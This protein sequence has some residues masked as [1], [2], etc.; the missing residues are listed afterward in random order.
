M[1]YIK[2]TPQYTTGSQSAAAIEYLMLGEDGDIMTFDSVDDAQSVIDEIKSISP[3]YLRPGEAAR[4]I[5]EII[6][7]DD[8]GPDC[9]ESNWFD[10]EFGF[11]TIDLEDVP[12]EIR[13]ALENMEVRYCAE[14]DSAIFFVGH[15]EYAGRRYW[16]GYAVRQV[17]WQAADSDGGLINWTNPS[18][19]VEDI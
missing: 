4:P 1:Y 9:V 7:A 15:K 17:A 10:N 18:Y 3:Y 16:I 19:W 11:E 13:D 14:D 5:Y 2:V 12:A 6:E 8:I